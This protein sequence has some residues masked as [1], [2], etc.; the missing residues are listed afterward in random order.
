MPI[1]TAF[2]CLQLCFSSAAPLLQIPSAP[3]FMIGLHASCSA[4][5]SWHLPPPSVP[6]GTQQRAISESV[7]PGAVPSFTRRL[8]PYSIVFSQAEH[9]CPHNHSRMYIASLLP[10]PSPFSIQHE[11]A[12]MTTAR[13]ELP[14]DSSN[15]A[16]A[17]DEVISVQ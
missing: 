7:V 14:M 6:R 12:E 5:L 17:L 13:P 2:C 9:E 10:P 1:G 3:S 16:M 11:K 8:S 15:T 4:S